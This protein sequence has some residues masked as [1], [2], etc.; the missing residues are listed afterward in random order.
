M[1][2]LQGVAWSGRVVQGGC[3]LGVVSLDF[4]SVNQGVLAMAL[5]IPYHVDL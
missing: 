5:A 1:F 3:K 2:C 4:A